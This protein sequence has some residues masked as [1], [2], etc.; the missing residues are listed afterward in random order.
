MR[1]VPRSAELARILALPRRGPDGI[2]DLIDP[3]SAFLRR[4]HVCRA[5]GTNGPDDL[6]CANGFTRLNPL[7]TEALVEFHDTGGL[8][9]N[10]PLG[11]GKTGVSFMA[12]TMLDAKRPLLIIPGGGRGKTQE[13]LRIARQHWRIPNFQLVSYEKIRRKESE[14]FFFEPPGPYDVVVCDE[15]HYARNEDKSVPRRVERWRSAWGKTIDVGTRKVEVPVARVGVM[16]ATPA[17]DSICDFAHTM[18]WAHG[19]GAPLPLN[20]SDLADW[21]GAVDATPQE[22]FD[23]GAL[24]VFSGG[25]DSLEMVR[26]GLAKHIFS[27][28]GIISSDKSYVDARLEIVLRDV[29]L[30]PEEDEVFRALR[31]DPKDPEDFPGW[32]APDGDVI[33]DATELWRHECSLALGYWT[34]W[35]PEPP[36]EWRAIRKAYHQGIRDILA[37]SR[38]YD[39]AAHVAQAIDNG[40]FPEMVEV[41]AAWR[42]IGPTFTQCSN[43]GCTRDHRE[44][45]D[46][47]E[48]NKY[49]S[50]P[51]WIGDTALRYAEEWIRDGGIVWTQHTHFGR[52]LSERTGIPY[53]ED[54]G[55]TAD[56]RDN[57][58]YTQRPAIAASVLANGTMHN[59]QRYRRNLFASIWPVGY[60]VEQCIGRTHRQGQKSPVVTVDWPISCRAQQNGFD[61]AAGQHANF[62]QQLL[63]MPSRLCQGETRTER[64]TQSGWAFKPQLTSGE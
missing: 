3:L 20:D 37:A 44:I 50:L 11:C 46:G 55:L 6:G 14:F 58:V 54:K 57:I 30:G 16:T 47:R 22:R 19:D 51:V 40:H 1:G 27:T 33:T 17:K 9:L 52:K 34:Y 32:T 53:F 5:P 56:G 24:T 29:P 2:D 7:Q 62:Y 26:R 48:V 13:D 36:R 38:T 43:V 31:G 39:T 64:I 23:P 12:F 45:R 59:L 49:H 21:A 60:V 25:N 8:W 35:Q 10:G 18:A 42:E 63:T 4:D 41:L 28:P 61:R 15:I